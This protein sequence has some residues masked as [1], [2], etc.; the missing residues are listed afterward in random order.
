M[1]LCVRRGSS[2]R[3]I[4]LAL[5]QE[6]LIQETLIQETLIQE[7]ITTENHNP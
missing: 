1:M 2:G 7:T 6:T 4:A 5:I 3:A